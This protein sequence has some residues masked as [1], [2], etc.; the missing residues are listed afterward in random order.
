MIYDTTS[1]GL[2]VATALE[3]IITD[4]V[5]SP[6]PCLDRENMSMDATGKIVHLYFTGNPQT[7]CLGEMNYS[8]EVLSAYLSTLNMF[9]LRSLEQ[10]VDIVSIGK[11]EQMNRLNRK[12]KYE[13][14]CSESKNG[15]VSAESGSPSKET[16]SVFDND[17]T[18]E[19]MA[20]KVSEGSVEMDG[21]SYDEESTKELIPTPY[22]QK[23][24]EDS[25]KS[26]NI[27]KQKKMDGLIISSKQHPT[28]ILLHLIPYLAPSRPFV[29]FS[30]YKEPLM[31]AYFAVKETGKTVFVTLTETWLRNYQVLPDRTHPE[32]LMSG[33]GG[34]IL[35]GLVVDNSDP[36]ACLPAE[37]NEKTVINGKHSERKNKR[38]RRK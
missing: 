15:T 29:V 34:Y 22:R 32:V 38:F 33:G 31:D 8:D 13:Y 36:P 21:P 3:R 6:E 11:Q 10:G 35:S 4:R 20:L 26:Y 2:I 16:C 5:F 28:S 17:N 24:R 18:E 7:Q 14:V 1:Q 23:M 30:S 37:N 25:N 27:I 12:R 19:I 9:H